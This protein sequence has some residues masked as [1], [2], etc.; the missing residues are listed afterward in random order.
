MKTMYFGR[1]NLG[2]KRRRK[3]EALRL[4]AAFPWSLG[5]ISQVKGGIRVVFP[6]IVHRRIVCIATDPWSER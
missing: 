5:L 6:V 4:V 1:T 2:A 3:G